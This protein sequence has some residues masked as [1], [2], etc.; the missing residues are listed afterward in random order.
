MSTTLN[1]ATVAQSLMQKA[2][3]WD[4]VVAKGPPGAPAVRNAAQMAERL[5]AAAALHQKA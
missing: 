2:A 5:R 1:H 4:K 3:E